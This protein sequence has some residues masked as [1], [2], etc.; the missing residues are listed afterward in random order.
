MYSLSKPISST[1]LVEHEIQTTGRPIRQPFR[2]QNPIIR[3]IE[4][5]QVKE[6]LRDGVVRPSSS[7]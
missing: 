5:Q 2:Q 1:S 3:D 6:M 4:Q 7:P